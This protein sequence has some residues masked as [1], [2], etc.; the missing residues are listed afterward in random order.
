[1]TEHTS[2]S[3]HS[4]LAHSLDVAGDVYRDALLSIFSTA[5]HHDEWEDAL[6]RWDSEPHPFPVDR[7]L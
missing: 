4:G 2:E 7:R 3:K 1:M 6:Q 5:P